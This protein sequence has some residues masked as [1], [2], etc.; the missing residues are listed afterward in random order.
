MALDES[1]EEFA[2]VARSPEEMSYMQLRDYIRRLVSSGANATRYRVDLYAKVAIA[3]V[4]L[5][6]ALIGVSFGLRTGR[7]GIMVWVGAC[8]P[9]GF[10]YYLLLV[11]GIQL[12]RGGALSPLAAAWLPN[13]VFGGAGLVSLWRLRG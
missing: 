2:R 9:T 8:I 7:A 11:L 12:G 3:L 5:I 1:P 4:S 6:M 10:V 13:V